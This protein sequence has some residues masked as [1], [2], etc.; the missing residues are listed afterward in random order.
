M[1]NEF[2]TSPGRRQR[3]LK[4]HSLSVKYFIKRTHASHRQNSFKT[5]ASI[6]SSA[7]NF[8][9][10]VPRF[11]SDRQVEGLRIR[12]D[13]F[14]FNQTWL[15]RN[16]WLMMAR[17]TFLFMLFNTFITKRSEGQERSEIRKRE[18]NK[19]K[20]LNHGEGAGEEKEDE[21]GKEKREE[22]WQRQ[23]QKQNDSLYSYSLFLSY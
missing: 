9:I 5:F 11:P 7:K 10:E 19:E 6:L 4:I 16:E 17:E 23:K 18:S 12:R 20:E 15:E 21:E 2:K 1:S 14:F 22:A 13:I 3:N 8:S